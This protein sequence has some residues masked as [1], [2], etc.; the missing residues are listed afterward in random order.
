MYKVQPER[1]GR[2]QTVHRNALKVCTAP[3]AVDP[4]Q[5]SEQVAETEPLRQPLMYWFFPAAVAM[6]PQNEEPEVAPWRSTRANFGHPSV[7]YRD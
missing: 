1:G 2:E 6:P 5:V 3:P 4:P 7:R